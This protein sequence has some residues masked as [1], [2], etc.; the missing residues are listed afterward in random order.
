MNKKPGEKPPGKYHYNP[1]NMSGK[2]VSIP[3]DKAEQENDVDRLQSRDEPTRK[4]E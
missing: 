4:R 1:G 3:K 2:S